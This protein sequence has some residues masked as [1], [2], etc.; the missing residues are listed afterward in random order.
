MCDEFLVFFNALSNNTIL[1][2]RS[3]SSLKTL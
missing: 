1:I 2:L 3:I